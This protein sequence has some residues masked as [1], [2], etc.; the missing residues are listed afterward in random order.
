[1]RGGDGSGGDGPRPGDEP[2]GAGTGTPAQLDR[3]E[4]AVRD[5]L[6]LVRGLVA[7]LTPGA[8]A[9]DRP[10]LDELLAEIVALQREAIRVGRANGEAL[11][12]LEA[13]L[14]GGGDA[15]AAA[16]PGRHGRRPT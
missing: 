6:A 7:L 13:R 2:R 14:D 3:I 8:D 4:A 10:R 16:T 12:R 11:G 5:T 15:T 1:M 9:P